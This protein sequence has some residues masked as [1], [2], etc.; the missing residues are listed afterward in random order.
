M[1]ANRDIQDIFAGYDR[2]LMDI[3]HFGGVNYC[4]LSQSFS[5]M[6]FGKVVLNL[7]TRFTL[8]SNRGGIVGAAAA[9]TEH[10]KNCHGDL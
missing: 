8:D 5:W 3:E 1:I 2:L 7:W 9:Y 10:E 4:Y 6:C